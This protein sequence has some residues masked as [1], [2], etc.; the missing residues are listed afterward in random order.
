[1]LKKL[2][3][4]LF[5]LALGMVAGALLSPRLLKTKSGGPGTAAGQ[6][7]ILY[8]VD[9]MHP[10][11]KSD[12]PGIAPDCG[13]K[14]EPVYADGG[15]GQAAEPMP[16]GTVKI[17]P[18]KQQLIGVKY[19]EVRSMPVSRTIRAVAKVTYDETKIARIHAKIDG[20]I[21]QVSVD[22][23]GKEVEK[24]QPLLSIYSPELL[25]TQQEF[26][27]AAKA[28]RYLSDSPIKEV[29]AGSESLYAA[30]RRRL[31][32]WDIDDAQIQEITKRNAPMKNLT[33][34]S[35]ISGYVLARNAFP[36]QRVTPETELYT[37]AD[38]STVWVLADLYEYEVGA[39]KL[40]Q[41]AKM[42]LPYYAGKSLQ[43]KVVYINPQVDNTSRTVKVRLEFPNPEMR[44]KPDMYANVEFA[45]NYGRQLAVP[46]EAVMD[47]GMETT[48]FVDRGNGYLE[49][50]KVELGEKVDNVYIV[51]S[52]LKQGERVVTSGNFLVDS[53][54]QL[55]SGAGGMAGMPGMGG[56]DQVK[57][58][59]QPPQSGQ[60]PDSMPGMD[61]GPKPAAK[62]AQPSQPDSMPGM[63]T[64]PKPAAKPQRPAGETPALPGG[65]RHD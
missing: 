44:L 51:R 2:F 43:G 26:L 48:V 59:A 60:Q 36:R 31:E 3:L 63:D 16:P 27:L 42:T 50:R 5:V 65:H 21:D 52:G 13:M 40:G 49:P 39:I 12:K 37:I 32:L 14:L 46:E 33:L 10:A 8:Y 7:K 54:S 9:P 61:M 11:Y 41:T 20:W 24:G 17:T 57:K 18:E 62:P 28:R 55:K 19:G 1:M 56:G 29:A 53:E 30:A 58:P 34:Y 64:G 23:V 15:T 4:F 45:V 38:L 22:F 25:A 35:P 47:S 6:R